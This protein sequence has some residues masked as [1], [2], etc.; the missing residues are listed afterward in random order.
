MQAK[1]FVCGKRHDS[2]AMIATALPPQSEKPQ[3]TESAFIC[4]WC[5]NK[6]ASANILYPDSDNLTICPRCHD[7]EI[8]RNEGVCHGC[9]DEINAYYS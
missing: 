1:C 7:R 3:L 4:V 9:M 6:H 5:L 8:L 2:M